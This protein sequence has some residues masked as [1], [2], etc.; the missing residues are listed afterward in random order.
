MRERYGGP[1]E[2]SVA[3][4]ALA[5]PINLLSFIYS[6]IYIP[7]HSN[8]LKDCAKFLGFE[9]SIPNASGALAVVW[10]SEWEATRDD[11][12]KQTLIHYNAE[13]CEALQRL[14]EYTCG[15]LTPVTESSGDVALRTVNIDALPVHPRFKFQATQ[16]Q[17][18]EFEA[19]NRSA[20]W[21]YQRE[22]IFVRSSNRLK[23]IVAR[24]QN[25]AR[26]KPRANKIVSWPAPGG[27]P[28]CGRTRIYKHRKDSKTV[29]DVKF[30]R[31]G[32]KRWITKY[33][34]YRYRCPACGAV[35]HN[36]DREWASEKF[37]PNVRAFSV[38]ANISL[39]MPQQQVGVFL[40]EVLGCDL[41]RSAT[42][43]FKGFVAKCYEDTYEQLIRKTVT[44]YLVHADETKVNLH[45]S[46]GYVWA[47]TNLEEVVYLYTPSREGDLIHS[48]LGDFKGVLVSDFYAAYDSLDCAQQKCLIHLIRDLNEDLMTEPFNEE[49][50]GLAAEFA[51]LL[52]GIIAT[53]DRFGLKAR[54]LR[55]HKASVDRFFRRLGQQPFQTEIARKCKARLEKNRSRLFTFLDY[56]G[57]PWN[58]NNAE[59]AIKAIALLRRD[60]SGLSTEK[61]IREYSILLSICETCK[62]KRVSFLE[63]LRSG[64]RDIDVFAESKWGYARRADASVAR[65]DRPL[66]ATACR[67]KK[68]RLN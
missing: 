31:H 26:I 44:G 68:R 16:F 36:R 57:V 2:R 24:T 47:L 21:D 43:K 30:G 64:E 53:V 19:I 55:A 54:F 42:N 6:R 17:L 52:K 5:A 50:K 25:R 33:L 46:A 40:N 4:K 27:C 59:H 45:H 41:P 51:G 61:G 1:P 34:F 32:I 49:T 18:P 11:R 29:L 65:L 3:E 39:R 14:T 58:N 28:T 67:Q 63:F 9:W 66:S 8:G 22:K 20:Y 48:L 13:D 38:Y 60:F 23:R 35:F 12:T 7:G 62:C 15:L 56:D 10:R 37:G